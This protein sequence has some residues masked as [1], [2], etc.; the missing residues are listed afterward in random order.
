VEQGANLEKYRIL[1][2]AHLE[3]EIYRLIAERTTIGRQRFAAIDLISHH[4]FTGRPTMK[5]RRL[6]FVTF[7]VAA[8]VSSIALFFV[9]SIDSDARTLRLNYAGTGD[10]DITLD[11][12]VRY[13]QNFRNSPTAPSI[14]G[15]SFNRDIFDKILAQPG[16]S[17]IRYYYAKKDDGTATIV[18][19]G[20]DGGGNDMT[21]GILGDETYPCP[22]VCGSPNQLNK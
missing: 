7:A 9:L 2:I 19:V 11:Q 3:V 14:K 8:L 13:I 6:K 10:H 22:P 12:A 20:V 17:G 15:G 1:G 16:C 4:S 18:I 5:K 21:S